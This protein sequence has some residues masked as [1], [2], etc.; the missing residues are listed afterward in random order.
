M[1][2]QTLLCL[3]LQEK[4]LSYLRDHSAISEAE[5][6]LRKQLAENLRAEVQDIL[7]NKFSD[8]PF[9]T[10]YVSGSF[11]SN[12]GS[13]HHLQVAFMLPLILEPNL[14][15]LIP[16]EQTVMNN[17]C[18]WLIRRT[19]LEYFPRGHS[20]WDKFIVGGY[21][22]SNTI[23]DTLW[24]RLVTSVN[25]PAIGTMLDCVVRPTMDPKELK[26]EVRHEQIQLEVILCPMTETKDKVLL[27]VSGEEPAEN[28]WHRSFHAAEV[29][30][31]KGL[32]AR[33]S[34]VRQHCLGIL[35]SAFKKHP[36]WNKMTISHLRQVI[37]HLSETE[38]D[39]SEARLADRLQEVLEELIR[40]LENSSLP[41]YFDSRINLFEHLL[42]EEID[43][44]G[45]ALYEAL[46]QPDLMIGLGL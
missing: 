31:L 17:P 42:V 3:T 26:L 29:S 39:W 13:G 6:A 30:R 34:G 33:D 11:C 25:W 8:L 41:C 21:L 24:K 44:I 12:L 5:K 43:E 32:D 38:S 46:I 1:E 45:Y 4:L 10:M 35:K 9:G 19:G 15:C 18:F 40:C 2:S 22:S 7:K 37:L 14:W 23:N 27:A 16:G 36:S 28:L 20:P